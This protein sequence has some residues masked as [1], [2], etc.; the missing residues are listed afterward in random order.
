MFDLSGRVAFVT[1]AGQHVGRAIAE[2][3]ARQGASV[4]V[5][6]VAAERAEAVAA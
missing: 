3:L 6:D 5:N 2:T 4:A 1:G